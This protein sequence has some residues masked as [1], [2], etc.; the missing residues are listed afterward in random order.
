MNNQS[1]DRSGGVPKKFQI[2]RLLSAFLFVLL[3]VCISMRTEVIIAEWG[4][5]W[6]LSYPLAVLTTAG[7]YLCMR[8]FFSREYMLLVVDHKRRHG[9]YLCMRDFFSREYML[10]VV[11]HKHRHGVDTHM[12]RSKED[13]TTWEIEEIAELVSVDYEPDK[14]ETLDAEQLVITEVE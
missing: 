3:L 1:D 8:D 12:V 6:A 9:V 7:A 13:I 10:F 2:G 5:H 14:G 11:V 4:A